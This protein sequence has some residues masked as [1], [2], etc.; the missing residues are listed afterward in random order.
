MKLELSDLG[1]KKGS[2]S[3]VAFGPEELAGVGLG[4]SEGH[5]LRNYSVQGL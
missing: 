3:F 4:V 1:G 5:V 2:E